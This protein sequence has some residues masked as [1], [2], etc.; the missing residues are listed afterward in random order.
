[1][2]LYLYIAI[3]YSIVSLPLLK[4][5]ISG[6]QIGERDTQLSFYYC[7]PVLSDATFFEYSN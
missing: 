2:G 1:M 6:V 5:T 4:I 3:F 7:S